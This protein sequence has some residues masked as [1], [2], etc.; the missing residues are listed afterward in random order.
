MNSADQSLKY[1]IKYRI[2]SE[3]GVII[4]YFK[5]PLICFM[6]LL[7][8]M[9]LNALWGFQVLNRTTQCILLGLIEESGINKPP[10]PAKF[11]PH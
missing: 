11:T 2:K 6:F 10:L 4:S 8:T 5:Q 7:E 1:R 3:T 9:I